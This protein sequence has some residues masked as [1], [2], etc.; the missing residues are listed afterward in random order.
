MVK[1]NPYGIGIIAGLLDESEIPEKKVKVYNLD[2]LEFDIVDYQKYKSIVM[3]RLDKITLK[4]KFRIDKI[5]NFWN[6]IG[7]IKNVYLLKYKIKVSSGFY[8]RMIAKSIKK[9]IRIPVHIYDINR[10]KVD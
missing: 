1:D 3:S 10:T 4:T 9:H 6:S 2:F 7:L 8:V 5:K